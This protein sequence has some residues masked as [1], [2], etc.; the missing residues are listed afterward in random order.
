LDHNA[1]DANY[2]LNIPSSICKRRGLGNRG[3]CWFWFCR[4]TDEDGERFLRPGPNRPEERHSDY[5]TTDMNDAPDT[6]RLHLLLALPAPLLVHQVLQLLLRSAVPS[7]PLL[8]CPMATTAPATTNP[9]ASPTTTAKCTAQKIKEIHRVKYTTY[10][11]FV[12]VV[13]F[14]RRISFI[15]CSV[16]T[17][18]TGSTAPPV[19]S[20][21]AV[22][23]Y[24]GTRLPLLDLTDAL[25]SSSTTTSAGTAT[26]G[27]MARI[28]S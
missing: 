8:M 23:L 10:L 7:S 12:W 20:V 15:F 1:T 3:L 16:L 9:N 6:R 17:P 26:A 18:T 28:S 19:H 27:A 13:Y 25:S 22:L 24:C 21:F 5:E 11:E 4:Y 14:T 2:G